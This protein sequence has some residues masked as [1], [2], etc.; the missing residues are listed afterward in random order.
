[1]QRA[2]RGFGKKE[3]EEQLKKKQAEEEAKLQQEKLKKEQQEAKEKQ[4]QLAKQS[5]QY[6][7]LKALFGG[8][9]F[10][11]SSFSLFLLFRYKKHFMTGKY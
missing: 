8:L 5:E 4:E 6:L 3:E 9:L 10:I 2:Y 1:M 11:G 7:W